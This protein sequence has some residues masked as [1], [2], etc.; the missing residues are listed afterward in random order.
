[1]VMKYVTRVAAAMFE[2]VFPRRMIPRSLSGLSTIALISWA[3]ESPASACALS[4]RRFKA[5]RA[6]SAPEKKK[7]RKRKKKSRAR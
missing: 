7:E 1:M 4:F 6:V 5:I 2:M 3:F